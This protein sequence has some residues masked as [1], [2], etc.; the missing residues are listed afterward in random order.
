MSDELSQDPRELEPIAPDTEGLEPVDG[1]PLSLADEIDAAAELERQAFAPDEDLLPLAL[2][3]PPEPTAGDVDRAFWDNEEGDARLVIDQFR[4]RF[5]H[6][7]MEDVTYQFNC[8]HWFLDTNREHE[9]AVRTVA[10]HYSKQA[11]LAAKAAQ[12][13]RQLDDAPEAKRQEKIRENYNSRARQIR[14][15]RRSSSIWRIATAGVGTLGVPGRGWWNRHPTLLP[16]ANCVVDLETGKPY[17]AGPVNELYFNKASPVDYQGLNAKA[18]FWDDILDKCLCYDGEL[19]AYFDL[20]AGVACTGLQTKDFF[21]GYGPGGDNGKSVIFEW[22]S[23]VLGDFAATINVALLLE[24]KFIRSSAGPSPDLMK[25]NGLRLAVGSEAQRN[26]RFSLSKIKQLTAGG[27]KITARSPYQQKEIEFDQTHTLLV[28][29]NFLPQATANDNAFYNRLRVLPFKARFV[30]PGSPEICPDKHV[31][32]R[33][34]RTLIDRRIRAE[35]PGILAWFVRNAREFLRLGDMPTPP[36]VVKAET[37][38]YRE[39]QDLVGQFLRQCCRLDPG[40]KEQ[41]KNLHKAFSEWCVE[42]MGYQP[43]NVP[44]MR[45]LAG[46][47]KGRPGIEREESR[48]VFYKGLRLDEQW[49]E[50]GKPGRQDQGQ[51]GNGW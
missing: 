38:D 39:E 48:V 25:F 22:M 20:F 16:C 37:Q 23:W 26:H 27:D 33:M 36:G 29:T 34:P 47:L 30:P 4:G 31:Y 11:M 14:T 40:S 5:C 43:K 8:T 28:H 6:D 15:Q 44:S 3:A 45:V 10:A 49:R 21:C 12:E 19:R 50:G 1:E 42:E 32:P 41:M 51:T 2:E 7:N 24:E 13:A 18:E 35:L 9:R 46:E 17:A